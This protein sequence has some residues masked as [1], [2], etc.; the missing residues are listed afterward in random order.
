MGYRPRGRSL[1]MLETVG[2][3]VGGT[4]QA[5]GRWAQGDPEAA[6]AAALSTVAA[7]GAGGLAAWWKRRRHPREGRSVV[8]VDA[9]AG[10]RVRVEVGGE[11][12]TSN[13]ADA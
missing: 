13:G 10:D 8:Q 1:V 9:P 5:W 6:G 12:V 2:T 11:S 3:A 4:L 7:L